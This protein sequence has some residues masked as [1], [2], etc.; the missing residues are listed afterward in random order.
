MKAKRDV[1]VREHEKQLAAQLK[2][3]SD[4]LVPT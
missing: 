3:D 4:G 1:L 2:S